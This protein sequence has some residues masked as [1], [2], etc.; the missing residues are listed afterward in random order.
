MA[1]VK[2]TRREMIIS[3]AAFDARAQEKTEQE[4]T[5]QHFLLKCQE[6]EQETRER[7]AISRRLEEKEAELDAISLR[8]EEKEAEMKAKLSQLEA[9][10]LDLERRLTQRNEE[11]E[12]L[13]HKTFLCEAREKPKLG[14]PIG[15]GKRGVGGSMM[16]EEKLTLV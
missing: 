13:T 3:L 11:V 12:T 9:K 16:P 2:K 4:A 10:Q 7:I 5:N 1:I 8:L 14:V 6:L 15:L